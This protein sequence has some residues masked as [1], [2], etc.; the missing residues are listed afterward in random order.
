MYRTLDSTIADVAAIATANVRA[1]DLR[2]AAS[3][4]CRCQSS[5]DGHSVCPVSIG[6]LICLLQMLQRQVLRI[7][8]A[9]FML[10]VLYV[11]L[12]DAWSAEDR[13]RFYA[14]CTV[15]VSNECLEN[16]RQC[17]NSCQRH[18]SFAV[19]SSEPRSVLLEFSVTTEVHRS[20]NRSVCL[21]PP[22]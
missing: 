13:Q 11:P 18:D 5:S 8:S 9:F 6:C 16:A 12:R 14:S 4:V 20:N 19:A 3:R 7:V 1:I 21:C 15:P 10:C 2:C 22:A 17:L